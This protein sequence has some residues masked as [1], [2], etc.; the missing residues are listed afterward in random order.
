MFK[1]KLLLS[2]ADN[3]L[4]ITGK[5]IKWLHRRLF[6]WHMHFVSDKLVLIR[7]VTNRQLQYNIVKD[8]LPGFL[9][10]ICNTSMSH[11]CFTYQQPYFN[12]GYS[13]LTLSY[14]FFENGNK[15]NSCCFYSKKTFI[16]EYECLGHLYGKSE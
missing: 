1:A 9:Y 13:L 8:P 5:V 15:N 4:N 10:A 2:V 7:S 12:R 16:N 11:S 3:R 6:T 14:Q